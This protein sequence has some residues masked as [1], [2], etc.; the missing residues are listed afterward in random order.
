MA[1]TAA[2]SSGYSHWLIK[3]EPDSRIEKGIDV[4]FSIDDF[5]EKRT[6]TWEGVRNHQAKKF[7]RDEM[8][9]GHE[10][11]FYASNCKEPGI[12]G[13]ARVIKE[14]YPDYNA[15]DPKHPYY[16]PKS[17]EENPT[18]YMVD[19]EFVSRLAHPVPLALLQLLSR[20]SSPSSLPS[21]L[22]SYLTSQHLEAIQSSALLAR[23]RLSVQP[24]GEGFWDAVGLL[25]TKGGWEDWDE[26]RDGKGKGKGKGV[27]KG[28]G[29]EEMKEEEGEAAEDGEK[30]RGKGKATGRGQGKGKKRK[31]ES[32]LSA[33]EEDKVLE[34]QEGEEEEVKPTKKK[35][36]TSSKPST[37]STI[38]SKKPDLDGL[39]D[40]DKSVNSTTA[41]KEADANADEETKTT[42]MKGRRNPRRSVGAGGG[43]GGGGA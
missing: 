38:R 2:G 4:K 22:S 15:W 9:L 20:H 24:V 17:K 30:G 27:E 8:K 42:T 41:A 43:G 18:W 7:L 21:S 6:T 13:I 5:E 35:K 3:A 26:W 32:D 25:G 10:C 36:A 12:R 1:S 31:A 34:H 11:L 37:S 33:N 14:G 23:G 28:K 16:D 29:K 19:V 39:E 40:D